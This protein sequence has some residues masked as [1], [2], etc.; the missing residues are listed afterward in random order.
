MMAK[1][2]L[3]AFPLVSAAEHYRV[4]S[5]MR[6]APDRASHRRA[7]LSAKQIGQLLTAVPLYV[8]DDF[9]HMFGKLCELPSAARDSLRGLELP[10]L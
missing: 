1:L 8:L 9:T 2:A 7:L 6:L 4:T 5:G 3:L 10:R